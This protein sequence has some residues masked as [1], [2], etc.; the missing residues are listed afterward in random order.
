MSENVEKQLD[1]IVVKRDGKKVPFNGT[2]IALAIKKGFDSV[3]KEDEDSDKKYTTKD[4]YKV[5]NSVIEKIE[6]SQKEKIKIEEIQDLIEET[7]KQNGYIDVYESFSSYRERRNQSRKLFFDE[8]KQHKLLK[9]LENLGL[10]SLNDEDSKKENSEDRAT[11]IGTMLQYGSAVSRE[12]AIAYLVKRKYAEAHDS[13]DI[14]IHNLEFFPMGTTNCFQID[15]SRLYKDGFY[16]GSGFIREP[17]D[18]MS[19]SALAI[20]AIQLSQKDLNGGQSIPAFDYFM[21]PGVLKTFKKQ[22]RQ[23]VYDFLDYT[24]FSSFVAM[25]GIEREIEKIESIGF[26]VSVFDAYCRGAEELHRLFRISYDKAIKKTNK[27]TYQAMEAFVHNLNAMHSN[28]S[29]KINFSTVNLGTDTS[30]EGRMVIENFLKVIDSWVGQNESLIL[31]ITIFKIKEGI[32]YNPEDKNYDLFKFACEVSSKKLF[33]NFSF[34]DAPFNLKYY[35]RDDFNTEVAYMGTY[36]R[37]L[38]DTTDSS[39]PSSSGRGNL[40]YTSINL[41]RIAIKHGIALNNKCDLDGFFAELDEKIELVK[42]QLLERFEIQCNKGIYNFPFI[43]GQGLWGDGEKL[44]PGDR[45]RKLYKHGTISLGVTGLAEA[46]KALIGKHHGESKEAQEL[47]IN[48]I[49]H[50][51]EKMDEY[52]EKYNLNFTLIATPDDE[53]SE[54]FAILDRTIYGKIKGVTDRERYTNSF[55]IPDSCHISVSNKIKLEAPYHEYTNGGHITYV[56]ID[57]DKVKNAE[58][59]EKT[60]RIMKESGIG[61]GSI[62]N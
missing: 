34:I 40:S 17:K 52:S 54:K 56:K 42:D 10:K 35:N 57:N 26:D 1:I 39:K 8:K 29:D 50:M 36:S 9:A 31:P 62:I 38:E 33:L 16:A 22:F 53:T 4:V 30:P 24:N 44:K 11:S 41:P 55:H 48:I 3:E 15:L 28:N 6:H 2:K 18:I 51:R 49:K 59:I 58:E 13:G 37:I 5:F 12:F 47:G 21:A 14:N 43:L 7:L 20:I 32:N 25:N 46:L 23:T 61:Y 60:V 19:Y 45:L 27:L